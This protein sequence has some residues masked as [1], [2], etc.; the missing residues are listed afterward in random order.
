MADFDPT[1]NNQQFGQPQV[2][3][4]EGLMGAPPAAV[5]NLVNENIP[6]GCTK[7]FKLVYWQQ[8]FQSTTAEVFQRCLQSLIIFKGDFI[9][10]VIQTKPDLWYPV[11]NVITL[12]FA[13][14]VSGVITAMVQSTSDVGAQ[15]STIGIFSGVLAGYAFLVPALLGAICWCMDMEDISYMVL[16]DLIVYSMTILIPIFIFY[17]ISSIITTAKVMRTVAIIIYSVCAAWSQ[18]FIVYHGLRYVRTFKGT[19]GMIVGISLAIILLH[20][21]FLVTIGC[22]MFVIKT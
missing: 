8:F 21:A 17:P 5:T 1:A 4:S 11:W 18:I 12:I 9:A 16:L 15:A 20:A 2:Q 3:Y 10:D 6:E 14:F 19:K 7:V 13:A 22:L